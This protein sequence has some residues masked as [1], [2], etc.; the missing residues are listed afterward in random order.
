[1]SNNPYQAPTATNPAAPRK[2]GRANLA[3]RGAR[4]AGALVD[5]ILLSVINFPIVFFVLVPLFGSNLQTMSSLA[6][7]PLYL[8]AGFILGQVVFLAVQG[9]LLATKGQTVGKLVAQ[10]RI[11]NER[12]LKVP[13]FFPMYLKRYFLMAVIF[14]IPFIGGIVAIVNALLIFRTNHKCLHDDIA[15]TIVIEA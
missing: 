3:G 12:T 7:N 15:G 13:D 1:M 9:Y 5:G 11:V 10:T 14:S 4:F 6:Y 2:T 8:A